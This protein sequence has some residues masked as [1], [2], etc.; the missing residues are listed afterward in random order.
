M[1]HKFDLGISVYYEGGVLTRGACAYEVLGHLPVERDD[2][3][4]VSRT[5]RKSSNA[6]RKNTCLQVQSEQNA[7]LPASDRGA[8]ARRACKP[9]GMAGLEASW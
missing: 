3:L 4:I 5:W 2:R 8:L 9:A 6:P 1:S 7:K